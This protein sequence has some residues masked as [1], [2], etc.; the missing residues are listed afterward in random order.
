[1]YS[2]SISNFDWTRAFHNQDSNRK[3]KILTETLMNILRSF[4]PHKTK[5]F[6]CG[7]P[8]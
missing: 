5:I 2:K 3:C 1:M 8:E 6:D 4:V 7:T